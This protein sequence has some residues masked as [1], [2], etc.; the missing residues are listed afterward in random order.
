[1]KTNPHL[2][3]LDRAIG[4]WSVTG[5]HPALPGRTL[6]GTV[7]F[8][9]IENGA[10][11]R[12]HSKMEDADIPEGV[13]SFGT[14]DSEEACTMLYFDV[15]A[16]ARLYEVTLHADGYTWTRD[17]PKFSQ[18]FRVTFGEDGRTMK[19]EGEMKK[20]GS[21]WEPDLALSYVRAAK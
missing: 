9:R 6:R 19:A 7:T 12:M 4:T 11:V 17:D 13:A 15:R 3:K 1:M 18:R 5:S 10:F 14:D 16:V 20:A 21:A 2:A 8:E